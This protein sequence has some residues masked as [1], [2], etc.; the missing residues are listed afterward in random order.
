M[1]EESNTEPE[2]KVRHIVL[3]GGTVYGLS[4]YGAIRELHE[5][6]MWK[7]E[8][9]KS[10]YATSAGTLMAVIIAMGVEWEIIDI[11]L[12]RRPWN[13]VFKLSMHSLLNS[14]SNCGILGIEAIEDT[15]KPLFISKD[16]KPTITL[17][18]FYNRFDIDLHF[19]TVQL[20]TFKLIDVSYR[21]HPYWTVCEAVY[22][23]ACAPILFKPFMKKGKAYTDGGLIANYPVQQCMETIEKDEGIIGIYVKNVSNDAVEKNNMDLNTEICDNLHDY[24]Q[25]IVKHLCMQSNKTHKISNK[26]TIEIIIPTTIIP[27]NDIY[28]FANSEDVRRKLIEHGEKCCE[29]VKWI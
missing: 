28:S 6:K 4:I 13:K 3:S 20:D 1:I 18:E 11:Y 5:K 12:T 7:H 2:K 14:Y 8:D 26:P 15:L 27:I 25:H 16:V 24:L 29:N 23:S 19:M 9:I 21:T 22:A 10:I 17:Q